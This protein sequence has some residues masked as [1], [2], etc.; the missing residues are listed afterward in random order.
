[1]SK[2][3]AAATLFSPHL[4]VCAMLALASPASSQESSRS[5]ATEGPIKSLDLQSDKPSQQKP[6]KKQKANK[7]P[8]TDAKGLGLDPSTLGDQSI[9]LKNSGKGSENPLSV[10]GR[11]S[12][13]NDPN[14]GLYS[15]TTQTDIYLRNQGE[16]TK[17]TPNKFELGLDYK[18]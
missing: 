11:W 1:M 18:Y 14:Y 5:I 12:A 10:N 16:P 8:T 9:S 7:P 4:V 13:S 2:V 17:A 15:T 6:G 3:K